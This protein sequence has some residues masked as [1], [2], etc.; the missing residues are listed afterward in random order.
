MVV[1]DTDFVL[2]T[3]HAQRLYTTQL[4]LLNHELLVAVIEHTAQIGHNHLLASSHIRCT[5]HNLLRLTFAQVNRC[6]MQMV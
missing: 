1:A 6:Y 2:S 4:R 3:N 5:T